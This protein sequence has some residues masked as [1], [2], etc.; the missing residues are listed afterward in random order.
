[1]SRLRRPGV[2]SNVPRENFAA[3]N[4]TAEYGF[5]VLSLVSRAAPGMGKRMLDSIYLKLG[6]TEIDDMAEG[7][8][9]LWSRPYFDKTASASTAR[10]TA[11]TRRRCD[12]AAPGGLRG[13]VRLVAADRAGTTTTS[14]YTERYMW[15]PQENKEGYEAGSAMTYAK[16]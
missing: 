14:I 8:K 15:I 11:A 6:M 7:V 13:R 10:R 4:A 9:A 2:G 16:T 1:M 3:P 5:L 12:P